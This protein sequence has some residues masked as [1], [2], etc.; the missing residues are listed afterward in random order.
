MAPSNPYNKKRAT[1]VVPIPKAPKPRYGTAQAE[2]IEKT[3]CNVKD[4]PTIL[5]GINWRRISYS[6]NHLSLTGA[7]KISV[8]SFYVKDIAI[9]LPHVLIPEYTP[10]CH[11]C[12][13]KGGVDVSRWSWVAFPKILHGLHT[14]RYLDSVEYFCLNCGKEFQAWNEDT[15]RLDGEEVTGVLNFRLSSGLAVDEELYSFIVSHST[16]TTTLTHQ[17]IKD[18]QTDFWVNQAA[19]YHRAILANRVKPVP[20]K[21]PIEVIFSEKPET[22]RQKKRKALRWEHT[23]LARQLASVQ[24]SFDAD[25]SFV[26]I[27]KR[28]ENRNI[29][30]EIFPGI[31]KA[32]CNTLI[33][34]GIRSAKAL[35]D[36]E[37][38]TPAI[39]YSWKGIVQKHYDDLETKLA[40]VKGK[41]EAA[42]TEL[43]LDIS[44]FGDVS[45]DGVENPLVTEVEEEPDEKPPRFS[46]L[47]DP[48]GFNCRVISRSTINRIDM[49]DFQRRRLLQQAKMR[50][51]KC[52]CWKVDWHYKLA[53][54]IKVYTGRGKC[55]SPYKSALTIQNEDALTVFWKFYEGP[56]S[57]ETARKD[58]I[59]LQKRNRLLCSN[60]VDNKGDILAVYVDNCCVV[61]PKVKTITG[62]QT[63]I[64]LDSFHWQQRWD[65][66]LH[67][68]KS[69]K[70]AIF[71][72]LMRRAL[73][74]IEDGE[75]SRV[76]AVL[77]AKYKKKPTAREIFKEAKATIPP[78]DLLERRVMAVLH[79]LMEKDLQADRKRIATAS[80]AMEGRF[81][82]PGA[83]T[84]N[85]II[86]QL[87]HVKKGCLSDPPDSLFNMFRVNPKTKKT[88]TARSTGTNEVD[89]RYLNHLLDT[90]SVGLTR[91]DR[92][93]HNYYERSN[94]NKMVNRLGMEPEQTCRTEQVSMLHSLSSKCGFEDFPK[95]K[96][97]Y[98]SNLDVLDERMGF[99]Y[100]LP[101]VFTSPG[102]E[103]E[104]EEENEDMGEFLDD[105][106]FERPIDFDP[107]LPHDEEEDVQPIDV[108]GMDSL[109][110]VSIYM[111]KIEENERTYDT[112]VRKTQEVPW[113]PFAHPKDAYNFTPQDKAE[114]ELFDEMS[115]S[116]SRDARRLD[117]PTGYRT[118]SKAWDLHVANRIRDSH[119]GDSV[120]KINRKSF[121][122]LQDHY[123]NL[124]KQKELLTEAMNND[125][126]L[127]R[128][129]CVF[130][131]TRREITPHQSATS[132]LTNI[133]YNH[134]LG[135]PQFGVPLALNTTI[136]AGAFQHRQSNTFG[137][138]IM[139]RTQKPPQQLATRGSLGK[140]FKSNKYCWRCGFQKKTHVRS[141]TPF[142]DKCYRNCGYEQC[143]KCNQRVVDCHAIGLVGPH[144][145]N[146]AVPSTEEMVADWWKDDVQRGNI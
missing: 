79:A 30:G 59:L 146:E 12:E 69:E 31:G 64:K 5:R 36:Y 55:F 37:G 99:D 51:I 131:Q 127:K 114:H 49:T 137:P 41:C 22:E 20:R 98:P 46:D 73:F 52:K 15:L 95:K 140:L 117:G 110:D 93:I 133:T 17:R 82:K 118:F 85:T 48:L 4:D 108:F 96:P 139:Y 141:G 132:Q 54:K 35:L 18:L 57:I 80:S 62:P 40:Y 47:Y 136:L 111:P 6:A 29:V 56:E 33:R 75:I 104:D 81:F 27:T 87:S 25:V 10:T 28:K 42:L 24:S 120:Q 129:E 16:D 128:V 53:S 134:T 13:E 100:H 109:V 61:G 7:K 115:S 122:Q 92:L 43:N 113:T 106:D 123:D 103:E 9:W 142:G 66:V 11:R 105:I 91:A 3:R 14:H 125:E 145:A 19:A 94:D 45:S 67:D 116:Y 89:N 130:K 143:S 23:K 39:K 74:L 138:P 72:K 84:L 90:P 144:C 32:K 135:V 50:S 76:E 58:L 88:Y 70:T 126:E 124:L 34:N 63:L 83:N 86:N 26:S 102:N 71:R 8:N 68:K 112:F 121:L 101:A 60:D 119:T 2:F 107:T 78:P 97:M 38:D 21:G 77:T 44:I 65:D 1:V